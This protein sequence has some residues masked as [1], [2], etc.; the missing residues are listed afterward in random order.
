MN[1]LPTNRKLELVRSL[2]ERDDLR[3]I[4]LSRFKEKFPEASENII[5]SLA[6]HLYV[7]GYDALLNLLCELELF[8]RGDIED[9]GYGNVDEIIY[10]L[11]NFRLLE[12]IMPENAQDVINDIE[13]IKDILKEET[14]DI[15]EVLK[16]LDELQSV[17]EGHTSPPDEI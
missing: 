9:I 3:Q 1:E 14:P 11:Y 12:S 15:E 10:H 7:D 5:N 2:F 13:E 6:F 4:A 17:I 8:L 16:S